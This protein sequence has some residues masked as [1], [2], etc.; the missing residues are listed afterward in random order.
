RWTPESPEYKASIAYAKHHTFIHAVK[1]LEGLIV[2]QLFELSKANLAGTSYKMCKHISKAITRCSSAICMALE[3]YNK[4]PHP[5][6]DY[7][8]VISYMTLGEFALLKH[9]C[10]NILAK[11]WA[12]VKNCEMMMKYFKVLCSQEEIEHLNVEVH[13]LQTWVDFDNQKIKSTIQMLSTAG[14]VGLFYAVV[15]HVNDLHHHR[16]G[17]IYSLKG[18]S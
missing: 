5:K 2:Q 14:S 11:L 1:E 3:H 7:M 9:S 18:Y 8:E 13:W 12:L 10:Y 17:L 15:H 16:L 6:L 4:L